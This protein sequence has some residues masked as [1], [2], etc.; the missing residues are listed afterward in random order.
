MKYEFLIPI[1]LV[2][3]CIAPSLNYVWAAGSATVSWRA[4][5]EP[6][7]AGYKIYYGLFPRTGS[8]PP[9]GYPDKIDVGKTDTP[10]NPSYAIENLEDGKTYYFSLTSYD[11]SGNESCFSKE[12]S[13]V[14]PKAKISWYQEINRFFQ[15][16]LSPL[17]LFFQ[18]IF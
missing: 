1:A 14:I 17:T 18:K 10:D 4:S 15:K 11:A 12:I 8:C 13:K 5:T 6:D 2:I 9:G 16:A 3:F 7:L